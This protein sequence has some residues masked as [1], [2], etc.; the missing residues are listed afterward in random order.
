MGRFPRRDRKTTLINTV[1]NPV[2]VFTTIHPPKD[3]LSEWTHL[4]YPVVV[5]GD[6]RSPDDLW[7]EVKDPLVRYVALDE[8]ARRWSELSDVMGVDCYA[9]K[10]FGYLIAIEAGHDSIWETDDDTFP[11]ANLPAV[12]DKLQHYK[13]AGERFINPYRA[14]GIDGLWPR[15]FPLT[16]LGRDR[17]SRGEYQISRPGHVPPPKIDVIQTLVT[18]DP[19]L[20]AIFRLTVSDA[21]VDIDTTLQLL[22]VAEGCWTPGN[23]QSTL[24]LTPTSL[25]YIF[26]P[27]GLTFRS[28]DIWRSY[29]AQTGCRLGL[30]DAYAEQQ[31]NRHDSLDEF[32]SEIPV[33]LRCEELVDLLEAEC[34][35]K[36]LPAIY[37]RLAEHAL[38]T[39][40]DTEAA[41]LFARELEHIQ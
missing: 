25:Q 39:S 24:W 19:D 38:G 9:R 4:G 14:F 8:Q 33:Y 27:R 36:E 34:I 20:D 21:P 2:V 5:V 41:T 17:K 15:G 26:V 3:R 10:N 40:S 12:V 35:G 37:E 1:P 30:C 22:E 31:R 13:I 6:R 29:I 32:E 16:Q 28:C 7:A 11:T 23:T 18:G